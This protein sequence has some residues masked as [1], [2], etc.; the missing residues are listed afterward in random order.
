MIV[1]YGLIFYSGYIS[2][3]F[4]M[5]FKWYRSLYSIFIGMLLFN[6][7]YIGILFFGG[8]FAELLLSLYKD[9][10]YLD[11]INGSKEMITEDII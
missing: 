5:Y 3:W 7:N 10:D 11:I 2:F 1:I 6:R 4:L 8:E 9:F